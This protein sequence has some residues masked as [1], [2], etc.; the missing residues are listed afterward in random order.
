MATQVVKQYA[1]IRNDVVEAQLSTWDN[2][3]QPIIK[4][5]QISFKIVSTVYF[6]LCKNIDI[7]N[8]SVEEQL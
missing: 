8:R 3:E 6:H 1:A 7:M 2:V 4:W 5:K